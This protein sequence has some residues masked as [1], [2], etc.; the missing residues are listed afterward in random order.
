MRGVFISHGLRLEMILVMERNFIYIAEALVIYHIINT[1]RLSCRV[2]WSVTSAQWS[3]VS[4]SP[5][6]INQSLHYKL[7]QS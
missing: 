7:C 3:L 2:M 6:I 5:D 1:W 4:L